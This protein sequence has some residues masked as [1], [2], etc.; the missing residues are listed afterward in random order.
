MRIRSSTSLTSHSIWSEKRGY[1]VLADG[2]F[3]QSQPDRPRCENR[4]QTDGGHTPLGDDSLLTALSGDNDFRKSG[5]CLRDVQLH[6]L[7]LRSAPTYVT[8]RP[9]RTQNRRGGIL[10]RVDR[11]GAPRSTGNPGQAN[12][13]KNATEG[14]PSL[15]WRVKAGRICLI[16]LRPPPEH[17]R[18]GASGIRLRK[19]EV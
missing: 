17:L 4:D 2:S 15:G 19:S 8:G 7:L 16:L 1:T 18:V 9:I 5:F 3:Q 10:K 11:R 12:L 6:G 13:R 14:R